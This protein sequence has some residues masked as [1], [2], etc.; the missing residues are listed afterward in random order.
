MFIIVGFPVASYT[1]APGYHIDEE[2]QATSMQW[3]GMWTRVRSD[4]ALQ[5]EDLNGSAGLHD[6]EKSLKNQLS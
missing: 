4:R 2:R 5:S 1:T 3:E 6:T